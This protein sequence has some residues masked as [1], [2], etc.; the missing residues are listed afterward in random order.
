MEELGGNPDTGLFYA[1]YDVNL[2]DDIIFPVRRKG[3][4]VDENMEIKLVA[5]MFAKDFWTGW[6]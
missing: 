4:Y 3:N 5:A 2:K 1:D 6:G